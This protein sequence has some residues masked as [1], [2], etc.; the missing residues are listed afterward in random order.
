MFY[1]ALGLTVFA[2]L[3]YHVFQKLI[4]STVNPIISLI[5]TYTTAL[6]I[7]FLVLP[8]FPS[9]T[10]LLAAFKEA[11]WASY[12]LALGIIGLEIGFLLAYRSGWNIS[13]AAV[14]SNVAVT[15][16]LVPVGLLFF[17]ETITTANIV[18]VVLCIAG[19]ILVNLK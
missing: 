12:A 15:I 5:I 9:K 7:C 19:I 6:I 2:N 4:S 13:L 11:N 14:A 3:L 10:P 16:L 8:F 18:G 17:N 1:F